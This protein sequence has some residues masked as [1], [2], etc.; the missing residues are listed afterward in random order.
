MSTVDFETPFYTKAGFVIAWIKENNFR[1]SS[2]K[3]K[4][5]YVGRQIA[6]RC[7]HA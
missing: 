3:K 4:P 7:C 5:A 2:K 6:R 1:S